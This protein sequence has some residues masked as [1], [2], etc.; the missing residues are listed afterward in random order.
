VSWQPTYRTR[1]RADGTSR[2]QVRYRD[3]DGRRQERCF[4]TPAEAE[5]FATAA[6]G[7]AR[8][9]PL[10]ALLER[11]GLEVSE[12]AHRHGIDPGSVPAL[13][14]DGL[15]DR[16]ADRWAIAEGWHPVQVWGWAWVDV[17]LALARL[18]GLCDP[19][20]PAA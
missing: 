17:G 6:V 15:S 9:W 3:L 8:R 2:T 5:A 4:P 19:K 13:V 11:C 10:E 18:T 14:R 1:I 16:D 12:F 7:A 20:E